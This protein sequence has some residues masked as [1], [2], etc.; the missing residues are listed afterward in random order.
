MDNSFIMIPLP[1]FR[2]LFQSQS[3]YNQLLCCGLYKSARKQKTNRSGEGVD[4]IKQMLYCWYREKKS[5]TPSITKRLQELLDKEVWFEDEDY[6]GFSGDGLEFYPELEIDSLR[7]YCK[8]DDDFLQEIWEW[9]DLYQFCKLVH[10]VR[11][12]SVI[13]SVIKMAEQLPNDDKV[14]YAMISQD[15][16]IGYRDSHK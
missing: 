11:D 9:Y 2:T 8:E 6:N 15:L 7:E 14:P 10:I 13:A 12:G 16:L 1:M 4:I 5:L 3:A